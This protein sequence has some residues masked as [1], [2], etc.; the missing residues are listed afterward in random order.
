MSLFP[1]R[2]PPAA[3][4]A[5]RFLCIHKFA[6]Y[7]SLPVSLWLAAAASLSLA[8]V[9]AAFAPRPSGYELSLYGDLSNLF[10]PLVGL[11]SL[12]AVGLL[13]L[14]ARAHNPVGL[15][16]GVVLIA[17]NSLLLESLPLFLGF[18][19]NNRALALNH[20]GYVQD[21]LAAQSLPTSYLSIPIPSSPDRLIACL[22]VH[23]PPLLNHH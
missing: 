18:S 11:S 4:P 10:L 2:D 13:L 7:I 14:T 12:S 20:I 6:R 23:F 3:L 19:A 16:A 9:I 15:S 17:L 5:R 21:M 1:R 22:P 8:I